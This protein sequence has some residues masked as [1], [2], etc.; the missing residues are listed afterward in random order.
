MNY[1]A[2]AD[3]LLPRAVAYSAGL[4]DYFFRG[5]L[6]ISLPDEGVYGAVDHSVEN[7]PDTNGFRKIKLKVRNVTP[8]VIP[9]AGPQKDQNIAQDM[10]GTVIA[11]VKYHENTCYQAD[12]SGEFGAR[13]FAQ[14]TATSSLMTRPRAPA[15]VARRNG[16]QSP[17]QPY[18]ADGRRC[19]PRRSHS[20]LRIPFP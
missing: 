13:R 9:T 1:D 17:M 4:I 8:P 6:E 15:A 12:L 10:S 3:L 18:F 20:R 5:R 11:V 14:V 2:A 19:E 16:S 7:Q